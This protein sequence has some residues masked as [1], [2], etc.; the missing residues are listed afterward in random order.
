MPEFRLDTLAHNSRSGDDYGPYSATALSAIRLRFN[1]NAVRVPLNVND[2]A[3]PAYWTELSKLVRTANEIEM[4]VIL[5]AREPG[6][7]MP[8][9]KTA[10]FWSQLCRVFQ[11]L[12]ECDL[13]RL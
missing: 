5:T 12:S 6:A 13:R 7:A 11:R 10:E 8:T 9:V 1:M 3:G 4:L 2:A